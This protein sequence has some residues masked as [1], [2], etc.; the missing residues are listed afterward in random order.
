[1]ARGLILDLDDT[2]VDTFALDALRRLRNWRGC[3]SRVGETSPFPGV[4]ELL[5]RL[6]ELRIPYTV[7]TSAPSFYAETVLAYHRLRCPVLVCYHDTIRHKPS[8][9]PV[10]L[11][12][13]R[14]GVSPTD[15]IGVG[16]SLSDLE[17]YSAAGV[18]P[19]A[20]GWSPRLARDERWAN[21]AAAPSDVLN[22]I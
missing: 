4:A 1:M 19:V 22:L 8:P 13:E 9:E 21:T 7:V 3:A 10:L 16:D 12:A 15:C 14:L 20:S 18:I 11:G 2:L 17:A 5:E 6:G